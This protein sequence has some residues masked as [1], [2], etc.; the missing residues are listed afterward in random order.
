VS[1]RILLVSACLLGVTSTYRGRAHADWMNV[2][3]VLLPAA[4]AAG[5]VFVPICPEQLGGL[6]TPR[7]PAEIQGTAAAV[8]EHQARVTTIDG[9]DVT[10]QFMSGAEMA[11]HIASATGAA[12]AIL[13]EKSPSC[14]V[15]RVHSGCF[16]GKLVPGSGLVAHL[17]LRIHI[18]VMSNEDF[19]GLWDREKDPDGV[20]LMKLDWMADRM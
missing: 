16:D 7:P 15:H 1:C 2:F 6:A 9:L 12:G 8:F 20:Q 10:R 19:V 3:K 11:A 14:G 13:S 4:K 18:P 17:L 5:V